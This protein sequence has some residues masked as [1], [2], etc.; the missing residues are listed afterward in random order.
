WFHKIGVGLLK[1]DGGAYAFHQ[2]Y[3]IR[4]A[5]FDFLGNDQ[6]VKII[7]TS[8]E[9]NGYAYILQK[10]IKVE[11]SSLIIGY[12]LQ[13]VGEKAIQTDEYVHNFFGIGGE[14]MGKDYVLF[15]PYE[16]KEEKFGANVNP[17]QKVEIG[18][19][20]IRFNGTPSEPFFFSN[21]TGGESKR[22]VWVLKN[23]KNGIIIQES[24]DF[25]TDKINLWG[26][27]H[28]ISPEL[29]YKIDLKAGETVRWIR[30]YDFEKL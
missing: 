5:Q 24:T 27:Q 30:K 17:E 23:H 15:F 4:P 3:E 1:K 10:E 21:L 20:D 19:D 11:G 25:P 9:S 14:W 29:F 18:K 22:A 7:C 8:E 16:L 26:T 2:P 12:E 28:V 13:N 6:H